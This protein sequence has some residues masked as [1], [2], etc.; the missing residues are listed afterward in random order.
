[1]RA[2]RSIR[3]DQPELYPRLKELLPGYVKTSKGIILPR[4]IYYA[5]SSWNREEGEVKDKAPARAKTHQYTNT[6]GLMGKRGSIQGEG[7]K[8]HY[9]DTQ[10]QDKWFG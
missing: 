7:D 1:M 5:L 4:E 3:E 8:Q 9:T 10:D 6:I 2:G